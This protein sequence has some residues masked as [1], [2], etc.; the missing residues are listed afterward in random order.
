MKFLLVVLVALTLNV[1]QS[2]SGSP[3]REFRGAWIATVLNLD[4]PSSRTMDV[5]SKKLELISMLDEL[6]AAGINAVMF[7]VRSEC[8]AFY[9]S[10]YEPWSYW[11][12]GTQ[13]QEPI[14]FFDP[15]EFAVVE[16]HKRGIELHAWL[17]PYRSVRQVGNYTVDSSRHV[18]IV[19]PEWH[20]DFGTFKMLDPGRPDVRDYVT[21]IVKDIIQRYDV[22][23]I[24]FDDY[25]YPYP[26]DNMGATSTKDSSS[27]ALD[28][29]GFP[30]TDSGRAD[31]RRDNVN[32]LVKQVHD[33]I[34]TIKPH[35]K[36]GIS[37]FGIWKTGDFLP[38]IS[39]LNAFTTIYC[40]AMAWLNQHTVD[41][42][43]PQLYWKFGGGQDYGTLMPWWADSVAADQRH[44]YTGHILNASFSTAEL[45][46]QVRYNRLYSKVQG[47][48]FFRASLLIQNTLNLEDSLKVNLFRQPSLLPVMAWKETTPPNSPVNVAYELDSA[49]TPL[50]K[51][52]GPSAA[53]DGDT[54]ARYAVY[55]FSSF[56][57]QQADQDS[58]KNLL[59]VEGINTTVLSN[60]VAPGPHHYAVTALDRNSNEG[61]LSSVVSIN[62][63]AVPILAHPDSGATDQP[64]NM[65]L[66]W[67]HSP[68][69]LGYRLQISL[70][71]SFTSGMVLDS[72][73]LADTV[74]TPAVDGQK[75]YFWRVGAASPGG[76]S[77]SAIWNFTTG[78]P[79]MPLL[80]GP[81][82]GSNI[83]VTPMLR[84]FPAQGAQTYRLQVGTTP[85][86]SV[87]VIDTSGI[88]DT[89]IA[90]AGLEVLR[91]YYWR[92]RAENS[93]GA[94]LWSDA[95]GFYTGSV[96]IVEKKELVPETFRLFQ[97][98]P[99]P[100][101]PT[102]SIKFSLEEN[103]RASLRIYDILGRQVAVLVDGERPAGFT[104]I[105]FDAS[106][107]PTG[108]Y[109]AVLT[110]GGKRAST[111]MILMK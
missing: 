48:V 31:W 101:N 23:G 73:D 94:G 21:T 26:P 75:R 106:A 20:L 50:L 96:T 81:P 68:S 29:R 72:L 38:G 78:F 44:L 80:S 69:A 47:S 103:A 35:V 13:G 7:Q 45:P 91:T 83:T 110:S 89:L 76:T 102:T 46:A 88:A 15:L 100:F 41:Y 43:T 27:F 109:V 92:V 79:V 4:W 71:S 6:K 40:D 108:T 17:N 95:W 8:D 42:L 22:D 74:F 60:P 34:Q 86:F 49:N 77:F 18:S 99:N 62:A 36:F 65:Q 19:H 24:H 58:A 84:W 11:L 10:P 56:P 2:Q 61:P 39:G 104:T 32:L 28:N 64:S 53:S 37:P 1:A 111:K 55:R 105:L 93:V 87:I 33:T 63:P 70:D 3:K 98:Y 30:N 51:W 5:E 14:L 12:T 67:A 97:N 59:A 85:A 54:A 25:F 9:A 107:L 57:V 82:H 16:A 52:D 90:P 66:L